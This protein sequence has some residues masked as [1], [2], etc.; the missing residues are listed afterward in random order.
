MILVAGAAGKTVSSPRALD[1]RETGN[2]ASA[3][4]APSS[5]D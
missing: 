3:V 1:Q 2:T 4:N 5:S